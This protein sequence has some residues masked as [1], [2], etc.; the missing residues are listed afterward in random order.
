[1]RFRTQLTYML[2]I[3]AFMLAGCAG[4]GAL[5]QSMPKDMASTPL[6]SRGLLFGNADRASPQIS[7]DGTQLAFL[8]EVNG[9]MNVWVGPVNNPSAAQPIT[10][11]TNRGIRMYRWAQN[12]SHL[13]YVQDKG[14]DENW[15]VYATNLKTKQTTDLTPMPGVQVRI[16]EVSDK[17]PNEILLAIND[18]EPQLHDIYRVNI[19]TGARQL[20]EKNTGYVSFETDH[21]FRVRLAMRMTP[22]GG[23]EIFKPA[24]GG[25]WTLYTSV[26]AEDSLTTNP[27]GFD[28]SG[29]TLYMTDS[30]GRDTA[31]LFAIDM[32][33]NSQKM[34]SSNDK[35]DV[36]GVMVHP[37]ER[38]VQAVSYNYTRQ[39]WDILDD[40]VKSDMKYLSGVAPGDVNVTSRSLDDKHWIVAYSLDNGPAR[41]YHY[42]RTARKA[43]FLFTNRKKLEGLPLARMHP[44]VI[45]SRDGMNLVSYLSLPVWADRDGDGRPSEPLPMVLNVHGGPWARDEWGLDPEHQWLT[46]RGYAVL[47]VNFRGSTG[48]GKSFVNAA[49]KEWAT[50][51]HDDLLDAVNWA[52]SEK[53][54]DAGKV[55]IYG[56]SYGGYATLVGLTFTPDVFCCGVDVVGPSNLITLLESIPPYWKPMLDMFTSRVGDPRTPEGRKLLTERSPLTHVDKIRKPLLIAQGANDPRVKQAE[57]DQIVSAMKAKGIPVTY[58]LYPDEGHGF[59]RPANR[60]AFYAVAEEFFAKHLGGRYEPVGDEF[61]SSSITAPH[62]AEHLP[63]LAESLKKS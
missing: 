61:E 47:S 56:G 46:N 5:L 8:A 1:M 10:Q 45:K 42:D 40:G 33:T 43:N 9:V 53:I 24:E 4:D 19:E 51:M 52:V 41:Y 14:G 6:V 26:P 37:T 27:S 55:A 34:L 25:D 3:G 59:A 44:V 38:T 60:I 48:F 32:S 36:Q 21:D 12:N 11:D 49:N 18:R 22:D 30:R 31:A 54:A 62:G 35:A 23:A 16:Q 17:Y 63:G 13:L 39:E 57:S 15:H 7:P 2:G 29:H 58:V 28:K 50:K 20:V